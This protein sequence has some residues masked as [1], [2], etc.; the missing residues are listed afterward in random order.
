MDPSSSKWQNIYNSEGR[1]A[2]ESESEISESAS[3]RIYA[4]NA[5]R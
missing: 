1:F 4:E 5:C 3:G 2:N